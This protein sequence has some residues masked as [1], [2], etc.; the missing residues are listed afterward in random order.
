MSSANTCTFIIDEAKIWSSGKGLTHSLIHHLE[1]VPN[2]KKLQMTTEMCLL[3]DFK[4][5]IA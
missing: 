1:T 5:Q 2:S 3:K 4:A